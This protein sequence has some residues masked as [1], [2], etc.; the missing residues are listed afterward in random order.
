MKGSSILTITVLLLAAPF[1]GAAASGEADAAVR[2]PAVRVALAR[3]EPIEE[4]LVIARRASTLTVDKQA[5]HMP[6]V[7]PRLTF[8]LPPIVHSE[9]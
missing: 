9:K 5:P 2:A 7:L 1:A 3:V 8:D 6:I 4:I